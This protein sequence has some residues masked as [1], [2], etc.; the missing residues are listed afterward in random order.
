MSCPILPGMW[1]YRHIITLD[2]QE[3]SV[4]EKNKTLFLDCKKQRSSQLILLY[5]PSHIISPFVWTHLHFS[6]FKWSLSNERNIRKDADKQ[7]R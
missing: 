5:L 7:N 3:E 1:F 6:P 4:D 2:Q